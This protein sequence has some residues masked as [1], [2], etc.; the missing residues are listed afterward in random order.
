MLSNDNPASGSRTGGAQQKQISS[1]HNTSSASLWQHPY[2]DVFKYFKVAPA[3]DWRQNK[4][5]GDVEEIFVSARNKKWL[6]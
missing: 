6:I 1:S 3:P 5:Q 4:K 2:V